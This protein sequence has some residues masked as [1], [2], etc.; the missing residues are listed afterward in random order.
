LAC[1]LGDSRPRTRFGYEPGVDPGSSTDVCH[2]RL[3]VQRTGFSNNA[4][5]KRLEMRA[6]MS[7][8]TPIAHHCRGPS[9][10]G[11][12]GSCRQP[13]GGVG[14]ITRS[15][16][17]PG[18]V[19]LCPLTLR[20]RFPPAKTGG[21][22]SR[23]IPTTLPWCASVGVGPLGLT[24]LRALPPGRTRPSRRSQMIPH[25]RRPILVAPGVPL[26]LL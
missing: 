5:L 18:L 8:C 15:L 23:Q 1:G 17:A 9:R 11:V 2:P 6:L 14:L 3:V 21:T 26:P 22:G 13:A 24:R 20:H 16:F 25:E 19:A 12:A 10:S 7:R 4:V